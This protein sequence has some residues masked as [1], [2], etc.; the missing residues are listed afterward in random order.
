MLV[1]IWDGDYP[2]HYGV[3]TSLTYY[4]DVA[5]LSWV[6][7]TQPGGVGGGGLTDAEL[8]ASPVAVSGTF[9]QAT[10]PVS[11]TFWQAVQPISGTVTA[12]PAKP[13]T[14]TRTQVADTATDALILA[15]N[16]ARFGAT[17][18]NDSSALLYLGLGTTAVSATNYTAKVYGNGYYEAPANF[19]GEIRGIWA[20]D[21]G[22]GGAKVTELT[23]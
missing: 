17:V 22:D 15:S 2:Q 1:P 7:G 5:T 19:T 18:F 20:T 12:N 21:P 11:G 14:G 9:W 8:R 4:W 3:E 16:A 13:G 23:A 10:Q 6:K